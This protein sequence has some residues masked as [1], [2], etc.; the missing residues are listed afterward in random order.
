MDLRTRFALLDKTGRKATTTSLLTGDSRLKLRV[1]HQEGFSLLELL[2][3]ITLISLF[4][5]VFYP[6]MSSFLGISLQKTTRTVATVVNQ[7]YNAALLTGQ[8]HRVVWDLDTQEYWV[9][10][11]PPG[12]LLHTEESLELEKEREK[13]A[14]DK[15]VKKPSEFKLASRVTRKK[16]K[17][18]NGVSFDGVYNQEM[19]QPQLKEQAF[20]HIFPNGFT[21]KTLVYLKDLQNTKNSL[22]VRALAG[23]TKLYKYEVQV[24]EVFQ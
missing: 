17:L 9:E 20:T 14:K 4:A 5:G 24:N 6:R 1:T 19:E 15:E 8:V 3:V 11:G 21:E 2:V 16:Q 23:K 22:V 13:L 10:S 7:A 12:F 18:P